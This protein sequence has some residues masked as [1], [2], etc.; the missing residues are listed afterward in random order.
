MLTIVL[1]FFSYRYNVNF[2]IEVERDR[3]SL[4]VIDRFDLTADGGLASF[5]WVTNRYVDPI[6]GEYFRTQFRPSVTLEPALNWGVNEPHSFLG[7]RGFDFDPLYVDPHSGSERRSITSSHIQL[8]MWF[9]AALFLAPMF[10]RAWRHCRKRRQH[11]RGRCPTCGYDLRA[12]PDRCPEC[13]T[14]PPPP[15]PARQPSTSR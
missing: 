4:N 1:W 15:T 3:P 10:L 9:I 12:T 13:G 6:L 14:V 7:R 11:Q 8:P 5:M 2:S